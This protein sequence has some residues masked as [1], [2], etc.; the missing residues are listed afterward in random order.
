MHASVDALPSGAQLGQ[1]RLIEAA[2]QGGFGILYRAWDEKLNRPVAVKECFPASICR[3][4]PQTGVVR[5]HTE[6]LRANYETALEDVY[7]EAQTL[8]GL[9]HAQ[10]VPVYDIFRAAGSLFYV[11][12]WLEGGSLRDK[13]ASG[14][15]VPAEETL[16]WLLSLLS[17]LEYLHSRQIIHRDI[18]PGNIMFDADGKPVLVDFGS[19][20]NRATKVDTTTQGEFSPVYAAPEQVSGKGKIGPWSDLYSLAATWYELLAGMQPEPAQQRLVQDDLR[21]LPLGRTV[22]EQS[23]MQN[24]ALEAPARCQSAREWQ[25]WLL[26]GAAPV[27]VARR[28]CSFLLWAV[29][30]VLLAAGGAFLLGRQQAEPV[31]EEGAP[32]VKDAPDKQELVLSDEFYEKA[33][34]QLGIPALHQRYEEVLHKAAACRASYA[35]KLESLYNAGVEDARTHAFRSRP[36]ERG[37]LNLKEMNSPGKKAMMQM[38]TLLQDWRG[39]MEGLRHEQLQ[40]VRALQTGIRDIEKYCTWNTAEERILLEKT[41]LRLEKDY[42][43]CL[44]THAL[45]QIQKEFEAQ[46]MEQYQSL[47]SLWYARAEENLR[48][49]ETE[50]AEADAAVLTDEMYHQMS[51]KRGFSQLLAE[52]KAMDEQAQEIARAGVLAMEN[53]LAAV[54][55]TL[56]AVDADTEESP[57]KKSSWLRIDFYN[58]YRDS[59]HKIQKDYIDGRL[60]ALHQEYNKVLKPQLARYR[61]D[62]YQEPDDDEMSEMEKRMEALFLERAKK[63]Y[64]AFI[65]STPYTKPREYFLKERKRIKEAIRSQVKAKE[66]ALRKREREMEA[67]TQARLQ[68]A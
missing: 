27:A 8:A 35:S 46:C 39:E 11:M 43:D 25:D 59:I 58:Q 60:Y 49:W 62:S 6:S 21:P 67:E 52:R 15:T 4:D 40:I 56:D 57:G 65:D 64:A 9:H 26:R 12:P 47:R 50:K 20:L 29:P 24:L 1:Y 32:Q 42:A 19:A 45:E 5:P 22:L 55:Q 37:F 41:G 63:E 34:Y 18:K 53:E 3:R 48:K 23:I 66:D 33:C 7:E 2:S 30:A 44:S 61:A 51:E 36:K 16:R 17:A 38:G 13:I 68:G 10:V 14:Q 31:Q 28:R 54:R